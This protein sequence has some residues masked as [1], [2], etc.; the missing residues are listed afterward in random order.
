MYYNEHWLNCEIELSII[1]LFQ[2]KMKK[3]K[4]FGKIRQ[5]VEKDGK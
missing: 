3:D 4:K 2:I 5:V 1:R